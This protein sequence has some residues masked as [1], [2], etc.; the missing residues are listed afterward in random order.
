M[1]PV[2]RGQPIQV[3]VVLYPLFESHILYIGGRVGDACAQEGRESSG[4]CHF[5]GQPREGCSRQ[6][7]DRAI[8]TLYNPSDILYTMVHNGQPVEHGPSRFDARINSILG[9]MELQV[10]GIGIRCAGQEISIAL[11]LQTFQKLDMFVY[12]R[13]TASRLDQGPPLCFC[14]NDHV[15]IVLCDGQGFVECN[16]FIQINVF[17]RGPK[18][19]DL[20]PL[21]L[22]LLITP[23]LICHGHFPRSPLNFRQMFLGHPQC[24]FRLHF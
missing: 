15:C 16:G 10:P 8:H 22:E 14:L 7:D 2:K 6:D 1:I 23:P 4:Q 17:A 9:L 13:N 21:L 5:S 19:Q 20:F 11:F 3:L 24:L 12:Q 18:G